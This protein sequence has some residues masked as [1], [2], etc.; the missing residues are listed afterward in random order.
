MIR[1]WWSSFM[2]AMIGC[3]VV[4]MAFH[5]VPTSPPSYHALAGHYHIE[6]TSDRGTYQGDA[7]LFQNGRAVFV[8]W[9]LDSGEAYQGYGLIVGDHLVVGYAVD[10]GIGVAISYRIEPERLVG[11]W[12]GGD[13][14]IYTEILTKLPTGQP[15]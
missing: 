12:P 3:V 7:Q 4:G 11:E 5:Q 8:R 6:G 1:T 15:A 10:G 2:F 9:S 13:A 14:K